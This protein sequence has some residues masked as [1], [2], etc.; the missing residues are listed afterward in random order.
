MSANIAIFMIKRNNEMPTLNSSPINN[1][2]KII[3]NIDM[4]ATPRIVCLYV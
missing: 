1:T 4:A 3:D 2:S